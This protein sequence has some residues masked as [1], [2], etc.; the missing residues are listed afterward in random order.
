MGH[1]CATLSGGLGPSLLGWLQ[2]SRMYVVKYRARPRPV[3][4]DLADPSL[5]G[6]TGKES[7]GDVQGLGMPALQGS[8]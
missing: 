7:Y 8:A 6:E 2:G 3:L 5:T 1:P 4:P